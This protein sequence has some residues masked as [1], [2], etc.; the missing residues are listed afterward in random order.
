MTQPSDVLIYVQHL[1]GI[2]HVKRAAVIA[3]ALA[4]RNLSVTLVSGGFPVPNLELGPVE[5][6]QLP[7]LKSADEAFSA[8][9]DE[10][11]RPIDE[12]F[13]V[14]RRDQLLALLARL[15]PRMLITELFPFGRRQLRFELMPLLAAA[16]E[17]RPRPLIVSSVRDLLNPPIEPHKLAWMSEVFERSYDRVLVHGDPSV[18]PFDISFPP[19]RA[20]GERLVYS[21]YVAE[22]QSE[23]WRGQGPDSEVLVSTGGGAVAGPLIEACLDAHPLSGQKDRRWRILVG[24]KFP[25]ADF[26][27]ARDRAPP[28]VVIERARPDFFELLKGCALSISQGGYNSVMDILAAGPPAVVVPFSSESEREQGLRARYLEDR[29]LLTRVEPGALSGSSL[30][31]AMQKALALWQ[32]R[33]PGRAGLAMDGAARSADLVMKW[34][35]GR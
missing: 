18:V 22:H 24:A 13:K 15:Q 19:A 12:A 3:R 1:L 32:D 7:P 29:G 30:A 35:D 8:L 23:A 5:L 16:D 25:K 27:A 20:L 28:G 2:G 17:L 34:L 33:A 9:V 11:G 10:R 21:G 26:T 6:V 4:A 14:A 31:N